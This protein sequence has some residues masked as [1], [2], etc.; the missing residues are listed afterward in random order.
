MD[1]KCG[2]L[3]LGTGG[4]VLQEKFVV[5]GQPQVHATQWVVVEGADAQ[6]AQAGVVDVQHVL[7][8]REAA[9]LA[10][11]QFGSFVGERG[12]KDLARPNVH[13]HPVDDGPVPLVPHD[14]VE[15]YDA[16]LGQVHFQRL[17]VKGFW[18]DRN[19]IQLIMNN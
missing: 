13:A 9:C 12:W 15:V 7:G 5:L 11:G 17:L 19:C 14:C 6:H 8:A 3:H 4:Q 1:H 10:Q 2:W 16:R 18:G